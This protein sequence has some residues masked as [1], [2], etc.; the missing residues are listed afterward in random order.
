MG[1]ERFLNY[2]LITDSPMLDAVVRLDYGLLLDKGLFFWPNERDN[3]RIK[4]IYEKP[5]YPQ[6]PEPRTKSPVR[7]KESHEKPFSDE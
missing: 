3:T 5:F 7:H 6:Q 4:L 2:A 1:G